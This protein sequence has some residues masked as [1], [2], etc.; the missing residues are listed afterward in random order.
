[1]GRV[2]L[3]ESRF[4]GMK[5]RGVYE[6]PGGTVLWLAHR[7]LETIT[8]DREVIALKESLLPRYA[9]MVYNWFWYA[10]ERLTLQT[11]IDSTQDVVT[12]VVRLKLYKGSV[13]VVGRRSPQSIYSD[14]FATFETDQVYDQGDAGGFIRCQG[15]RLRIQKLLRG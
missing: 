3:V 10:P 12:G 5:S 2:D 15:L 1:M 4:V 9:A 6:T 8:L 14:A 13:R 11:M 7:T